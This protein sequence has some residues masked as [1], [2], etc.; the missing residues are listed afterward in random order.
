MPLFNYTVLFIKEFNDDVKTFIIYDNK[1][2]TIFGTRKRL[3]DNSAS[4]PII[5]ESDQY[6]DFYMTF[7]ESNYEGLL[8]FLSLV[9]DKFGR[10]VELGLYSINIYPEQI[11]TMTVQDMYC[12]MVTENEIFGYDDYSLKKKQL[13]SVLRMIIYDNV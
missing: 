6:C 10:R 13:D 11:N 4:L 1:T 8:M 7:H 2:F 9:F 12:H 3:I 5:N